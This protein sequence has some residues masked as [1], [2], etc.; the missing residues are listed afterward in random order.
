MKKYLSRLLALVLTVCLCLSI[1]PMA[2]AAAFADPPEPGPID[3][4]VKVT[5]L[6]NRNYHVTYTAKMNIIKDLAMV[7]VT[8]R[9]HKLMSQLRFTCILEDELVSQLTDVTKDDFV[10]DCAKWKG[11]NIFV[12]ENATVTDDGLEIRYRLHD[13]VLNDWCNV[14]TKAADIMEALTERMTMPAPG[15]VSRATMNS[16]PEWVVTTGEVTLEG[17][18]VERVYGPYVITGAEGSCRWK[19]DDYTGGGHRPGYDKDHDHACVLRDCPRNIHCPAGHFVDLDLQLWYH[20]G[21]HF[22]AAHDLMVGMT[23]TTFEPYTAINRAMVVTILYRMEGEPAVTGRRVYDDVKLGTWYSDAV[24]W[25]TDNEVVNGYGGGKFGPMDP[26]TRE[27]MAAILWRYAKY[28]DCDVSVGENTNILSYFDAEDVSAYAIP[29]MQWA[30]GAKMIQGAG[31]YLM[32]L[33]STTRA[34]AAAIIQ[35]YCMY[36]GW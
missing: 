26:I 10:F 9:D 12:Y 25:A 6:S 23:G 20:D 4:S 30:C 35:R 31:G 7:A 15:T 22:C 2:S 14:E 28:K 33:D 24:E 8:F 16:L 11:V 32:P 17:L 13:D 3:M 18:G 29:A 21:I 27:Q 36:V 34:Q 1:V 19:T 5:E